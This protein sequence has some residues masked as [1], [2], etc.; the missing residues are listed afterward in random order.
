MTACRFTRFMDLDTTRGLMYMV[1]GTLEN[2]HTSL[3]RWTADLTVL[4]YRLRHAR[5]SQQD[6]YRDAHL[7]VCDDG[8]LE[9]LRT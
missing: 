4:I 9:K 7:S 6:L 1:T 8:C 3:L 5:L 2:P